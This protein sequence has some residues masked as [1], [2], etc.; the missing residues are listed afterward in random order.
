MQTSDISLKENITTLSQ[1]NLEKYVLLEELILNG[2]MKE[3]QET[4]LVLLH[5]KF[6]KNTQ[7][8]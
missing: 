7:N 3:E 4:R 5:K 1:D 2:L 6:K 8:L